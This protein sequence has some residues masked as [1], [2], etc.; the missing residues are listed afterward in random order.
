ME[1]GREREKDN[2]TVTQY[3]NWSAH[4]SSLELRRMRGLLLIAKYREIEECITFKPQGRET[5]G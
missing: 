2:E 5:K 3:K 4:H 1:Q